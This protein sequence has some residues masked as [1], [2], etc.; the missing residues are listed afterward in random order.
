MVLPSLLHELATGVLYGAVEK[1][2]S[3]GDGMFLHKGD[4]CYQVQ[5]T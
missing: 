3:K 1:A 4:H 5:N 2:M